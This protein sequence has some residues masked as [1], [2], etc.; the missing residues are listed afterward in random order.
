MEQL[1]NEELE[2]SVLGSM[3][4]DS[5]A[6][7]V[8]VNTL[9]AED[10]A[11]SINAQIFE[12]LKEMYNS[13]IA[14]D[15]VTLYS[16]LQ[17]KG[18][19]E[20]VGGLKYIGKIANSVP[21]SAHI[22]TY[23]KQLQALSFRRKCLAFSHVLEKSVYESTTIELTQTLHE[24]SNLQLNS[25]DIEPLADVLEETFK[26]FESKL[27]GKKLCGLPT[28][29]DDLDLFCGGGLQN[30]DY[31]VIAARPSMGKTALA[32]DIL[33]NSA[34]H[35]ALQNK[36]ALFFSLEMS[37]EKLAMRLMSATTRISNE[38][39]RFLNLSNEEMKKLKKDMSTFKQVMSEVYIDDS[40]FQTMEDIY[41][42]C[43]TQKCNRYKEIGLIIID[44]LQLIS[45]PRSKYK[46]RNN[47]V[48]E[49]SRT[50]KILAKDF[51]CPVIVLS[52]LSRAMEVRSDKR[53]LLSDLRDSGAIEQDADIVCFLYRDAYYSKTSDLTSEL[54]VAKNREGATGTINLVF[55][56]E[57]SSFRN[58]EVRI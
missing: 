47:E 17:D 41:S 49:I 56:K 31:I 33:R 9:K 36:I 30:S 5:D 23:C 53:P 52:Q 54:I 42:K 50:L 18:I 58:A 15:I 43:Y 48:S 3:L 7:L 13:K 22:K 26:N 16:H 6:A 12:A 14:L 8:A 29:F 39:F 20:T 44:Y 25:E 4:I 19:L 28:G 2:E 57:I 10:F 55:F 11:N 27:L 24:I 38:K 45:S 34:R 40:S 1:A 21:T 37:K 35:L 51:N 46:D 32:L